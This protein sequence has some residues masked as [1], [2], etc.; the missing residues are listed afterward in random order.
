MFGG[1]GSGPRP[2]GGSGG[3]S[4]YTGAGTNRISTSEGSFGKIYDR[5]VSEGASHEEAIEEAT[6]KTLP[7]L[8]TKSKS[9]SK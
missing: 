5:A 4:K 2:G 6:S 9:L 1:P 7:A 8:P 3:D